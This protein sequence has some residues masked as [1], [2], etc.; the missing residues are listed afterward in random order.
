[1]SA[2]VLL[3]T[4]SADL[5]ERVRLATGDHGLTLFHG[6]LPSD[7]AQLLARSGVGSLPDVVALDADTAPDDALQLAALFEQQHPDVSVVLVTELASELGLAAMRV[8]V[9][10]ILAPDAELDEIRQVLDRSV[11]GAE[12]RRAV[13]PAEI[14]HDDLRPGLGRVISVV[15]P[16][17]GVGKTTVSTNLAVGLARNAPKSTVLVDLDVQFGDVASALNLDPEYFLPD[18]LSAPASRDTMV[19]KTFLT[20]HQT[21]LYVVCGPDTPAAADSVTP[22]QISRLL[23]MLASEF[24]Y[25]VVD[26]APGLSDHTLAAMDQSTDLVLLTSMDVPGVRGLHKELNALTELGILQ[27]NGHVVLNFADSHGGLTIG[28]VEATIGTRVDLVIPRSKAAPLSMN[29]GVPLLQSEAKDPMT[30]QLRQLVGR[31]VPTPIKAGH[32]MEPAPRRA[33]SRWANLRRA[34]A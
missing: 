29:Q 32:P 12:S 6:E 15:S 25:V 9:R 13:I 2:R 8:G 20:L 33:K 10:D 22:Q 7:P 26:T 27:D 19:L 23:H 34:V 14:A 24:E 31:F 18:A 11:R 28:D 3:A 1:M 5:Y 4:S 30:R 17:G 16:K 21:G